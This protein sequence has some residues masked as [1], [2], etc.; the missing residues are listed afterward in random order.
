MRSFC[1]ALL[2]IA[3]HPF[4]GAQTLY[5]TVGTDGQVVYSDRP[6]AEGKAQALQQ[7]QLPISVVPG[8]PP[9]PAGKAPPKKAVVQ[10]GQTVLYMAQWCGYCRLARAYLAKNQISYREIDID[11][12]D[13]KAAFAEIGGRGVPLLL[14]DGQQLAGFRESRYDAL[15]AKRKAAAGKK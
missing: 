5:K 14:A 9:A 10:H 11:T 8:M 4:A 1:L 3:A 2:L 13:G 12:P 6:P 15:F 7:E